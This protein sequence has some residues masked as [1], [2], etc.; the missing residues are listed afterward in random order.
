MGNATPQPLTSPIDDWPLAASPCTDSDGRARPR[1][2][3]GGAGMAMGQCAE[4]GH[5]VI[6]RRIRRMRRR[7]PGQAAQGR[8]VFKRCG[9]ILHRSS[10]TCPPANLPSGQRACVRGFVKSSGRV[11]GG[12]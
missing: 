6:M 9:S 8:L 1:C 11:G 12:W 10:P 7:T 2:A 3:G 4:C 5:R